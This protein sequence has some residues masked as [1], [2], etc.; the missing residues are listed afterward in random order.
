MNKNILKENKKRKISINSKG[1][2][3]GLVSLMGAMMA[4]TFL[5]LIL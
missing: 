1:V 3:I 5:I 4:I 2:I